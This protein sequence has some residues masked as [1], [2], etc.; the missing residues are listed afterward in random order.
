[1]LLLMLS[2]HPYRYHKSGLPNLL[3][4]N[5]ASG[6]STVC[7]WSWL[8]GICPLCLCYSIKIT[9]DRHDFISPL[10]NIKTIFFFHK[11]FY[12]LLELFELV[13]LLHRC[14]DVYF[15]N[16]ILCFLIDLIGIGIGNFRCAL[17]CWISWV[18]PG[19]KIY[20]PQE[21]FSDKHSQLK[22]RLLTVRQEKDQFCWQDW[23][24]H[25]PK[26]N[27]Y[28]GNIYVNIIH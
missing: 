12:N 23:L 1:M 18:L 22:T 27:F 5:G 20:P 28:F 11:L 9:L 19:W 24:L 15:E 10:T 25:F 3:S 4:V 21:I 8:S 7:L 17:Y 2:M 14:K 13:W 16:L 26:K 6:I